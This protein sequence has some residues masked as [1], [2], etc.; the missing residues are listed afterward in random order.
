ME[1]ARY[2]R[3]QINKF[4]K[5]YALGDTTCCNN[6]DDS[7]NKWLNSHGFD[8]ITDIINIPLGSMPVKY[9][10]TDPLMNDYLYKIV[11]DDITQSIDEDLQTVFDYPIVKK[12]TYNYITPDII[13]TVLNNLKSTEYKVSYEDNVLTIDI[14]VNIDDLGTIDMYLQI[15]PPLVS[16]NR[17]DSHKSHVIKR[18]INKYR[19]QIHDRLWIMVFNPLYHQEL[20]DII[21]KWFDNVTMTDAIQYIE[22]YTMDTIMADIQHNID[23]ITDTY[24]IIINLPSYIKFNS[25]KLTNKYNQLCKTKIHRR[26]L[27]QPINNISKPIGEYNMIDKY[28]S[29]GDIRASDYI[30]IDTPLKPA[31][32]YADDDNIIPS[33][34]TYYRHYIMKHINIVPTI[35]NKLVDLGYDKCKILTYGDNIQLSLKYNLTTAE[36]DNLIFSI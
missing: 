32:I 12:F 14:D 22:S 20:D 19:K 24:P 35:I 21:H 16:Y 2:T 33:T 18:K 25:D 10:S 11:M 15:Q 8:F 9:A 27:N 3:L 29:D 4:L 13:S 1:R 28:K 30:Y 7:V 34:I 36:L 6:L 17:D 5:E 23:N 31:L 26:G